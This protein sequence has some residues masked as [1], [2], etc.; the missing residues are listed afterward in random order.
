MISEFAQFINTGRNYIRL[1]GIQQKSDL[2][3]NSPPK[4]THNLKTGKRDKK[5]R[6]KD[7]SKVEAEG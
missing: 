7:R 4:E 2:V 6:K 5:D 1:L 3:E